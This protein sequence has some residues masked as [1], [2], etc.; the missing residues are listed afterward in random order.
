MTNKQNAIDHL[1]NHQM[2]PATREDLIK[3]CNELSD[4]SDKDKEWFIKHL[5]EGTYKSADEVIKAIGL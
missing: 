4:F 1:N 3:E 2:Y 5:P